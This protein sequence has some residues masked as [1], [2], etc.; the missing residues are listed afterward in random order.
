MAQQTVTYFDITAEDAPI[1]VQLWPTMLPESA[2]NFTLAEV[3][4]IRREHGTA[5]VWVYQNGTER[6]FRLGETIACGAHANTPQY[7]ALQAA[8]QKE[9]SVHG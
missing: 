5:V 8:A 6:T 2:P 3:R 9:V 4:T 7:Q 1:G